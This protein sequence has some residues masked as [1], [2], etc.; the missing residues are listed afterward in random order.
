MFGGG[1]SKL[2]SLAS[3]WHYGTAWIYRD[4]A[5]GLI[6]LTD[7][8]PLREYQGIRGNLDSIAAAS[9]VSEFMIATSA[10]GGDWADAL[11]LVSSALSAFDEATSRGGKDSRAVGRAVSLFTVRALEAMGL[12]PAAI[13]YTPTPAGQ[14]VSSVRTAL[15]RGR[16]RYSCRRAC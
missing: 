15:N 13:R 6:K 2:R 8:D 16:T 9:F 10:L 12:M 4:T 1:K 14:A 7:F 3:P 5:K 11:S